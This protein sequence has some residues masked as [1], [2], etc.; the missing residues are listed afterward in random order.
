MPFHWPPAEHGFMSAD[1]AGGGDLGV[2]SQR[3]LLVSSSTLGRHSGGCLHR[4]H[5]GDRLIV[6]LELSQYPKR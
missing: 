5:L 1:L 2:L 3:S 4:V 6:L